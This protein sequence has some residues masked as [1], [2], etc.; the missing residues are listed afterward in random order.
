MLEAGVSVVGEEAVLEVGMGREAG[1]YVDEMVD[2]DRFHGERILGVAVVMGEFG[3]SHQLCPKFGD[4][5]LV[6]SDR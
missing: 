1:S 2:Y 6:I 3:R 4:T 5:C